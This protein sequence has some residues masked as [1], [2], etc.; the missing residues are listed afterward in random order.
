MIVDTLYFLMTHVHIYVIS[1][2]II[3]DGWGTALHRACYSGHLDVA[4]YLIAKGADV[5]A[6]EHRVSCDNMWMI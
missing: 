6:K 1:C 2:S 3:K 5:N 4:E